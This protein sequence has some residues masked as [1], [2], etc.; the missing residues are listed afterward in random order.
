MARCISA[1]HN[2]SPLPDQPIFPVPT[3]NDTISSATMVLLL[4]SGLTAGPAV[5]RL[6]IADGMPLSAEIRIT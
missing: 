2:L 3:F 4:I 1:A 6:G 5:S